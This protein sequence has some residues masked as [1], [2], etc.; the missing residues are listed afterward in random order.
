MIPNYL[1]WNV[2]NVPAYSLL[3]ESYSI[4]SSETVY[5]VNPPTGEGLEKISFGIMAICLKIFPVFILIIFSIL[6]ILSIRNAGKLRERLRYRCASINNR[7]YLKREVRTTRM[8]VL[9]TLC[10]VFV[11][12]P[13]GLL[14]ILIGID[15]KYFIFYSH[16]GDFWDISSISSSFITFVMYCSMS[17]QFRMEILELIL[18]KYFI[19]KFNLKTNE[20]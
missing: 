5:W 4:N 20:N 11:E 13:Q 7:T 2:I 19:N 17:Q 12:F 10:T 3:P 18:P 15:K 9:I 6:L 8:L 1:I 14:L 16:L